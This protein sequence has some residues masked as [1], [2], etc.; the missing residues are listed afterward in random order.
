MNRYK[1]RPKIKTRLSR[2]IRLL[3]SCTVYPQC[4]MV[5]SSMGQLQIISFHTFGSLTGKTGL[6]VHINADHHLNYHISW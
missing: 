4:S 6:S 1:I 5:N 3:R 2:P